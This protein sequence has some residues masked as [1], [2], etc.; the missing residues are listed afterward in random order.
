MVYM[1]RTVVLYLLTFPKFK[2]VVCGDLVISFSSIYISRGVK[3]ELSPDLGHDPVGG[4]SSK[5]SNGYF[6]SKV[7]LFIRFDLKIK[8]TM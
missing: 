8:S 1:Y 7:F 5:T 6:F 3:E 2:I 4:T